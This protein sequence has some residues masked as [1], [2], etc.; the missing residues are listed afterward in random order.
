MLYESPVYAAILLNF[1]LAPAY[2]R[3]GLQATV[4]MMPRADYSAIVRHNSSTL[5]S[6]AN[7]A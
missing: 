2:G 4:D 5:E 3:K 6:D 1:I 7:L